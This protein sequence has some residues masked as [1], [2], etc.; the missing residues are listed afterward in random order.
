MV[1]ERNVL[2]REPL[3]QPQNL[4]CGFARLGLCCTTCPA[5]PCRIDPFGYGPSLTACGLNKE[6]LKAKSLFTKILAGSLFFYTGGEG[7]KRSQGE[8]IYPEGKKVMWQKLGVMAGGIIE[9][10]LLENTRIALNLSHY[11]I[12]ELELA[13]IRMAL[14]A[15]CTNPSVIPQPNWGWR[16]G[17]L[18][19][20]KPLKPWVVMDASNFRLAEE[21]ATVAR[22]AGINV[23]AAGRG[24]DYL[25]W[26]LGWPFLGGREELRR[27]IAAG[28]VDVVITE[29]AA[30]LELLYQLM[31]SPVLFLDSF[32]EKE[33][34]NIVKSARAVFER[35]A[36]SVKEAPDESWS[37][38]SGWGPDWSRVLSE[39]IVCHK[40]TGVA[41]FIACTG[42]G[43]E[44]TA[45]KLLEQDYLV[46]AG[47]CGITGL[48]RTGLMGEGGHDSYISPRLRAALEEAGERLHLEVA[49]PLVIHLGGCQEINR[50][51]ALAVDTG[52]VP[53]VVWTVP[54]C[55]RAYIGL[56]LSV[57]YG[58]QLRLPEINFFSPATLNLFGA[59]WQKGRSGGVGTAC[60]T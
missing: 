52:N 18:G 24:A 50:G 9:E 49:L 35:R 3:Y 57:A 58:A 1:S 44:E 13:S 21:L 25:S 45:R 7:E 2:L 14:A 15:I 33:A 54:G 55:N 10:L 34:T 16:D 11:K 47:G 8:V 6:E 59:T 40:L 26:R 19:I 30:Q 38:A 48:I 37:F 28:L 43:V 56:A 31:G 32:Q 51:L 17:G 23:V 27:A 36:L 41:V 12:Y 5:G 42:E 29:D 46:L 20:L 4:Q 22:E 60:G 39:I 53:L